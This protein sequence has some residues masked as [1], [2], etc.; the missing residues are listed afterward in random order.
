MKSTCDNHNHAGGKAKGL[1]AGG[2]LAMTLAAGV[3][4]CA[5]NQSSFAYA[6][7][8]YGAHSSYHTEP[9]YS[10]VYHPA[11]THEEPIYETVVV[12]YR[13]TECGATK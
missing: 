11:V 6:D 1:I 9:V 12:G 7:T 5:N 13:C 3:G 8:G 10:D 2:I 4:M